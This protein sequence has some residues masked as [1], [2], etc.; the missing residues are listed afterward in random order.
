MQAEHLEILDFLHRYAPFNELPE[1]TLKWVTNT[2]E[3]SYFKAGTQILQFGDEVDALYLIRS[4]AV[5]VSRRNG[6]LYNRL[7]EGGFF[8]EFGL[9]RNKSVRFPAKA[10]EDCLIYLIP[11][12]VF[13]NLFENFEYFADYVEIEDRS[14]LHQVASRRADANELLTSSVETLIAREPVTLDINSSAREAAIKMSDEGVS[15][16]LIV[17]SAQSSK[18]DQG[19]ESSNYL[20]GIV[21]DVDIRKRLVAQ[22]LNYDTPVTEIMTADMV[23]VEYNQ[24][25][26]EAS[27]TMLRYN[28]HHLPVLKRD[29][30]I[31][32]IALSDIIRHE[33]HNS[34]VVVSSIFHQHS[35]EDLQ[36]LA[37]EARACFIRMV[38]EDA[39]SHMI[40][41]AMAIIGR[42]FKQ[43][44]LELGEEKFGPPPIPYCFLALGSMARDEQLVITDQDNAMVL[45]NSFD[46][47]KHDDYFLKLAQFVS[48]GLNVCGYPY[49]KGE[50]MATNQKWRKP[51][52]AWEDY[53]TDWIENPTPEALLN[54]SIFFDLDGV[55]GKTEWA[56]RLN[57]QIVKQAQGSPRFLACMARNALRRTPPL[58]F[59]KGFVLEKDGRHVNSF[60]LKRRGTAPLA[61]LIR[62]HALACGSRSINSFDRLLDVIDSNILPAGHAQDIRE[63]LEFISMVRIRH[64]AQDLEAKREPDNN[65]EPENLSEFER[66]TL[67]DAFQVLSSAQKFLKFRY[68]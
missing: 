47:A 28:I 66:R 22:G 50:I 1:D 48:D 44:L 54:S 60:N 12:P 17:N 11:E 2:I 5:E 30:P 36:P 23:S 34:L 21:T 15:S 38:N 42:S 65:V 62:V 49:C 51:L 52:K 55:W 40:G 24:F 32:V 3:I 16:V 10:L 58:G 6:D 35:V 59:F 14:R 57:E 18:P 13:S 41:G 25:V 19:E 4:G 33:S 63:A 64:Q 37:E 9:M 8:G 56:D 53:F 29:R 67:K 26:F 20:A 31:G 46:P 45:D 68:P 7:S 43:R 39:N 61:D 27:L